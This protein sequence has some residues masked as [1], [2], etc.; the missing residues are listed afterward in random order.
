MVLRPAQD[1]LVHGMAVSM[2]DLAFTGILN[3]C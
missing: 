2:D 1:V 3:I